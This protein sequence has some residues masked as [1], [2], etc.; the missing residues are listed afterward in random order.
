M[1]LKIIFAGGFI[2]PTV[3]ENRFTL[4]VFLAQPPAEIDFY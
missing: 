4:A 1:F 3:S 2:T